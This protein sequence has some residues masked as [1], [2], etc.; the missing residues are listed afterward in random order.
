M[1]V[2]TLRTLPSLDET[3]GETEGETKGDTT[4]T[5]PVDTPPVDVTDDT[6]VTDDGDAVNVSV[7]TPAS[8]EQI[9]LLDIVIDS[10]NAALNVMVGFLGIAQKRGAF[11]INESAKIFDAIKALS[12]P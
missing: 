3:E 9:N 5:A 12:G 10:P 8:G 11:A 4:D 6:V 1:S 2:S 7:D